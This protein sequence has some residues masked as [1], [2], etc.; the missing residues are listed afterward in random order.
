VKRVFVSDPVPRRC[1]ISCQILETTENADLATI[2]ISNQP[3]GNEILVSTLSGR[4]LKSLGIRCVGQPLIAIR[5]SHAVALDTENLFLSRTPSGPHPVLH[6]TVHPKNPSRLEALPRQQVDLGRRSKK[7]PL[8]NTGEQKTERYLDIEMPTF[9]SMAPM[10]CV[11]I[12]CHWSH[13]TENTTKII[14]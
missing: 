8:I 5:L 10:P 12:A 7:R 3:R 4:S 1:L 9:A 13:M 11:I 14:I 2:A 6:R